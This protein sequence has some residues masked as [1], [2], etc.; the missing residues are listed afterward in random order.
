MRHG[1]PAPDW[2]VTPGVKPAGGGERVARQSSIN[3]TFVL[4]LCSLLLSLVFFC[5]CFCVWE[6]LELRATGE[7]ELFTEVTQSCPAAAPCR[8]WFFSILIIFLASVAGRHTT[9]KGIYLKNP[10]SAERNGEL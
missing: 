10:L 1:D 2:K 8:I 5:F 9:F 7:R 3:I 4:L 6:A